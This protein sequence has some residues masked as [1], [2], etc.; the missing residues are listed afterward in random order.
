[1]KNGYLTK[2]HAK[3]YYQLTGEGT[4]IVFIHGFT[5]DHR[6]WKPQIEFFQ[7][8][9]QTL[10]YD[11][12]GYGKSSIPNSKYSHHN[13]LQELI[14]FLNIDKIHLVGLSL[15]GEVAIDF[16]ISN[17]ERLMSLS[18]LNS[19]LSGYKSTVDWSV[20]AKEQ[21]LEKAKKNWINHDI[22]KPTIKN[23][24]SAKILQEFIDD[25]SG[26]HWF[27]SDPR[28]R[29]SKLALNRLDEIACPTLVMSGEN[30][31]TYFHDIAD[32]LI[33]GIPN[34]ERQFI[35]N[36]GHMVN[37]EQPEA[38]NSLLRQFFEK[39]ERE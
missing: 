27:N 31:L 25:Y 11:M 2:D 1:M 13:D 16:S 39:C 26:W 29:V 35:K 5:L 23:H 8:D 21:G 20:H 34:A 38:V 17:P 28:K 3:I 18:L 37:I 10:V 14:D 15:G 22:F 9:Y 19:S 32:V 24:E 7:R 33:S 30:D 36:A 12:R 6:M 4:P